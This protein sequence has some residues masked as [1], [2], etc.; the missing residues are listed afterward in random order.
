MVDFPI[1]RKLWKE[2]PFVFRES[3]EKRFLD[4]KIF[5]RAYDLWQK[6]QKLKRER[7]KVAHELNIISREYGKTKDRKV[8]ERAEGIKKRLKRLEQQLEEIWKELEELLYKLPAPIDPKVPVGYEDVKKPIKYWGTPLVPKNKLEAFLEDTKGVVDYD[9]IERDVPT[10]ADLMEKFGLADY[11]RAA[12]VAGTRFYVEKQELALTEMALIVK[13]I[14]EYTKMGYHFIIP[15]FLLW[16]K[17]EENVAYYETFKEA[18]YHVVEDDLV[19]NPTTEHVIAAMYAGERFREKELPLKIVAFGP[20]FR[21]EAGAHGKDTKGLFR[22]HQF[23]KVELHIITTQEKQF[24]ALEEVLRDWEKFWQKVVKLPYRIVIVP[25]AEMDKRAVIQYDAEV[26]F[27]N[28]GI[29]REIGSYATMGTWVSAKLDIRVG[30][31]FVANIYGTGA[32][33]PRTLCALVENIYAKYGE[34]R[35]PEFVDEVFG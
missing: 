30:K 2:K 17:V 28:K 33:I 7:D 10:H 9:V 29:Y 6:W 24:D 1:D 14:Q 27:P 21:K 34:W 5:D 25:T 19:L 16:K 15:P 31:E 32:T 8:K 13:A 23:H 20:A 18:I 35:R 26:F 22:V 3:L 11:E 12:K 4:I